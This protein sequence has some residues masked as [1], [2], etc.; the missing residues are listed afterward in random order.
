MRSPCGREALHIGHMLIDMLILMSVVPIAY[1]AG[2]R[3]TVPRT[4][5][6]VYVLLRAEI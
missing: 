2:R 5:S 1:R 3:V 6:I 4:R